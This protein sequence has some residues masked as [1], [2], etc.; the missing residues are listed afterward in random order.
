[1][2]IKRKS[3][4]NDI[5]QSLVD[6]SEK[7]H[8]TNGDHLDLSFKTSN[9]DSPGCAE[10]NQQKD[11]T[12]DI[13]NGGS[14]SSAPRAQDRAPESTSEI[15]SGGSVGKV[16]EG[17]GLGEG[18]GEEINGG[19][20]GGRQ[21][22]PSSPTWQPDD[23]DGHLVYKLG[24]S[25]SARYKILSKVGEGTFGQVLECWDREMKEYVAVKVIRN[26]QKYRDAAMIEIDVLKKL[27]KA[28]PE[29]KRHCV[30]LKSSYDFRGHVCIVFEKLGL[31]LY[32][33]LR[34]N[35]YRPFDIDLVREFGAQMLDSVAFLHSLSLIHTDLKPENIL[36]KL[37]E[38][39]RHR[40]G[41]SSK[42][43]MRI[44]CSSSIKLIDFGSATFN[45]QYH[46]TVVS[47]RHYRAPEVILG[48]GWTYPCDL[49]SV[50]CILLELLSGDAVF[51]THDNLEHLAMME[52]VLGPIPREMIQAAGRSSEKYFRKSG[53]GLNW[54]GGSS[55]RESVRAVRKT[56]P[57]QDTVYLKGK[58]S[59]HIEMLDL[60]QGLLKYNPKDRLTAQ[61]A[62]KHPFFSQLTVLDKSN[63]RGSP[64]DR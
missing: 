5:I 27:G 39:S 47:T 54:P 64:V 10:E 50:G 23:K 14:L 24:E 25:L 38:Y 20:R 42:S 34:K 37:P 3:Q 29:G 48:L 21:A 31:S 22:K 41:K 57:L 44:P 49:W 33:F 17:G 30:A 43:V 53:R 58:T 55:G 52:A 11:T 18:R 15:P 59:A 12:E 45:D 7:R 56:Y 4:E 6:I 60:L 46:S 63:G 35:H 2:V 16:T 61:K 51:Q 9:S 8:K 62:L 13:L 28:D 19:G 32:D 1:M 40:I 36:L 26:V